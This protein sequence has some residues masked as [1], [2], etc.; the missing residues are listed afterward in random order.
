[1]L[2]AISA[3]GKS[4]PR[5]ISDLVGFHCHSVSMTGAANPWERGH[6]CLQ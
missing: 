3:E 2:S 1:M 6:P 5:S 4:V